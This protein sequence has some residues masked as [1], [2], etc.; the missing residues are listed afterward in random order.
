MSNSGFI[1]GEQLHICSNMEEEGNAINKGQLFLEHGRWHHYIFSL[2]LSRWAE[3]TLS[4]ATRWALKA[5]VLFTDHGED[6]IS[7]KHLLRLVSSFKS[8]WLKI[9]VAQNFIYISLLKDVHESDFFLP[10][11]LMA[12]GIASACLMPIWLARSSAPLYLQGGRDL[13]LKLAL[14]A[15]LQLSSWAR[16]W[17]FLLLLGCVTIC[18][19]I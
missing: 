9:K 13:L 14:F 5:Y 3:Q 18:E 12:N 1:N 8:W 17:P 7:S 10:S 6:K 11:P 2:F 16:G 15:C 4:V 19:Y